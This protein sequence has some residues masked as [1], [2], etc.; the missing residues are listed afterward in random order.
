MLQKKSWSKSSKQ[1]R[2]QKSPKQT[3][4]RVDREGTH[5]YERRRVS[6][7]RAAKGTQAIIKERMWRSDE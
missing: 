6:G 3:E 1:G 4:K 5:I 7:L 2:K